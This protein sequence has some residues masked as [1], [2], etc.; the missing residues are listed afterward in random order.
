MDPETLLQ[1]TERT[2]IS[3][4]RKLMPL[5]GGQV[6]TQDSKIPRDFTKF[7]ILVLDIG[8]WRGFL[9]QQGA[10]WTMSLFGGTHI[11]GSSCCVVAISEAK[12]EATGQIEDQ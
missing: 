12:E 2:D 3:T 5:G 11:S 8:Y 6:Q 4:M 7:K 9:I 10:R 1:S